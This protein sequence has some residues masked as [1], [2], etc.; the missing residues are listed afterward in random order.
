MTTNRPS[1]EFHL[2]PRG[3]IS[4]TCRTDGAVAGRSVERPPDAMETWL[5]EMVISYPHCADVYSWTLIWFDPSK[6]DAERK[7][8]RNRFSPPSETFPE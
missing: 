3:W 1:Q 7:K 8:V 5:E 4:G 2:T 6:G